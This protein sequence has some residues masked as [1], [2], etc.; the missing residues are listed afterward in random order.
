MAIEARRDKHTA[1]DVD[2]EDEP[3]EAARLAQL[4]QIG[5][6]QL[7]VVH[8]CGTTLT[9][10]CALAGFGGHHGSLRV[11]QHQGTTTTTPRLCRRRRPK[12]VR[13]AQSIVIR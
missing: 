7:V 8:R 12:P 3:M 13:P 10:C 2:D 1:A 9:C 6:V 11:T 4:P 5:A